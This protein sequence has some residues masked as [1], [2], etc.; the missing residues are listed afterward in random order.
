M[1]VLRKGYEK[2]VVCPKCQAVLLYTSTDIRSVGD[3]EGN[4]YHCIECL[5][6]GEIFKVI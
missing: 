3:M 1:R 6:C 4:E 5:D 2:V